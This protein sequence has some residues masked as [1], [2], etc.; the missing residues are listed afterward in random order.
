MW[1]LVA[2]ALTLFVQRDAITRSTENAR[3]N[4]VSY[5]PRIECTIA[6]T[7]TVWR[8]RKQG[9]LLSLTLN[10]EDAVSIS[11]MP[12]VHLMALPK[13]EGPLEDEYWALF[14]IAGEKEIHDWQR[15]DLRPKTPLSIQLAPMELVW[16]LTKSSASMWP[17]QKFSNAV[18]PGKY[19]L[20]VQIETKNGRT[21][22]SNDIEI[23]V[24]R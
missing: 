20:Q 8:G 2:L 3:N 15:I 16:G 23:T 9:P 6:T 22:L 17:T 12:S 13:K 11:V 10:S 19:N 4:P 14:A 7:D 1:K 5:G 24:A 21:I 18:S